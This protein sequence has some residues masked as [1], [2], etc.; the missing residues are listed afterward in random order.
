MLGPIMWTDV[1]DLRDFY[2]STLGQVARRMIRRRLRDLWP[3]VTGMNVLGL[4]YATPYLNGFRGEAERVLAAM[5]AAQGVLHWPPEE[6]GLVTLVDELEL[7]FPDLSMDR[8]L[9]V[10]ALECAEQARPMMRE[11][12]RVLSGSGRLL[13]VV[14]NR[15]GI[16]ARF[17]RTPFGHG[18]PHTPGQLS[19]I[20]RDSLFTPIESHR[21][22]FVP[23]VHSRMVLSSA[24]AWE[25]IGQRAFKTFSG[26]VMTEAVKQIYAA[27]SAPSRKRQR[28][29]LPVPE[30]TPTPRRAGNPD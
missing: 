12:W 23:P 5:P 13:V 14:P 3:N 17:E 19:R 24:P 8:V 28:R 11:I 25:Q 26:V 10:H 2:A 27:G 29:Y 7:P 21:A 4:G 30:Q 9:L 1:V 16:W 22:L 20:L 18:L 15:S 6:A